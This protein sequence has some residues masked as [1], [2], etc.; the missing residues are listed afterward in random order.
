MRN[1]R[2]AVA[3]GFALGGWLAA[4]GAGCG[5]AR[6]PTP[7]VKVRGTAFVAYGG[8]RGVPRYY[9][10]GA[11]PARPLLV[12]LQGSGCEPVFVEGQTEARA[13]AGQDLVH[14]LANGRMTVMVVDK[15]FAG[16]SAPDGTGDGTAGGCSAAFRASH[17]L[18][19]WVEV[20]GRAIDDARLHGEVD[21]A[22]SVRLVGLSEGAV[23][24]A[25]L[26]RVR[27]DVG[28]V[29]FVSGFGCDQ[30]ADM[31]VVAR[32]EAEAATA[33]LGDAEREAAIGDA[34]QR[35][36]RGLEAVAAD[37][38]NPDR[39]FEGQTHLFW[40]TFGRACPAEDLSRCGAEV[41][42]AYGT[43]DEQIDANGVEAIA[44]ACIAAGKPVRVERIIGGSHVLNTPGTPPF[45]NLVETLRRALDWMTAEAG[46][47]GE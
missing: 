27:K 44:A 23:T 1:T 5:A 34:V 2:I 18:E 4:C 47:Q 45:A 40:S 19:R 20:V 16:P 15:P 26:A 42:V 14:S 21:P 17:S 6:P 22:A 38:L 35:A 36:Q 9:L 30:W 29:A 13:T 11:G 33:G 10:A 24:A 31:L 8:E 12:L 7:G 39:F 25:R 46:R 37:P 3:A 28:H 32:R 43:A 41:L